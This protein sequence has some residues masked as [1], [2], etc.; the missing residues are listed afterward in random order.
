MGVLG[1]GFLIVFHDHLFVTGKSF[2]AGGRRQICGLSNPQICCPAYI[3]LPISRQ[4]SGGRFFPKK[5]E[6]WRLEKRKIE[7]WYIFK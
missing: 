3:L 1:D 4:G 7:M 2:R 6:A 5:V